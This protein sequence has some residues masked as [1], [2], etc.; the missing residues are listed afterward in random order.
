[1]AGEKARPTI[2][3][4]LPIWAIW[5]R[6]SRSCTRSWVRMPGSNCKWEKLF[7]TSAGCSASRARSGSC[8]R[9]RRPARAPGPGSPGSPCHSNPSPAQPIRQ[10]LSQLPAAAAELTAH[11]N[12]AHASPSFLNFHACASLS[13][14]PAAAPSKA[15]SAAAC[16]HRQNAPPGSAGVCFHSPAPRLRTARWSGRRGSPPPR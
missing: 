11:R 5:R 2:T 3:Q 7:Y 8:G 13:G 6:I 14:P 9:I 10:A 15:H 16:P 12:D 1:M 4:S